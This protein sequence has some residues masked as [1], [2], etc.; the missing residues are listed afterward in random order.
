MILTKEVETSIQ[1]S[2]D[3]KDYL[4]GLRSYLGNMSAGK[5]LFKF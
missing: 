2:V 5:V 1:S 4:Q 3:F